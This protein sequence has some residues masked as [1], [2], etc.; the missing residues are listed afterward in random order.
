MSVFGFEQCD[1]L[2]NIIVCKCH[3]IV[4][5]GLELCTSKKTAQ[6]LSQELLY[7]AISISWC[8]RQPDIIVIELISDR[9]STILLLLRFSLLSQIHMLWLLLLCTQMF[10]RHNLC[11]CVCGLFLIKDYGWSISYSEK[12]SWLCYT[13]ADIGKCAI[14]HFQFHHKMVYMCCTHRCLN[15]FQILIFFKCSKLEFFY[16]FA[17]FYLSV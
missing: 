17:V 8:K 11:L 7:Y 2:R 15:V 12:K 6:A 3:E 14:H 4:N 16:M 10:L 13:V 5:L 1:C 9:S